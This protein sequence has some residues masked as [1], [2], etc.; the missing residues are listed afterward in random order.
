MMVFGILVAG[1]LDEAVQALKA[2]TAGTD[3]PRSNTDQNPQSA[4][5]TFTDDDLKPA[6]MR[7]L[8]SDKL[9]HPDGLTASDDLQGHGSTE[10]LQSGCVDI[11]PRP[12]TR[13][14]LNPAATAR[15]AVATAVLKVQQ[16]PL[17]CPTSR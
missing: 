11:N 15:K 10:V 4:S 17:Y 12:A 3:S 7:R 13:R 2:T 5:G 9:P 6:F 1:D 16:C 14:R 8:T